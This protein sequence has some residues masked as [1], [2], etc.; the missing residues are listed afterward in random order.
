[1]YPQDS[2]K[3]FYDY[4]VAPSIVKYFSDYI[5]PFPYRKLANVQSKTIFGGMENASAIF[6]AEK[7]VTGDRSSEALIAHEIAHQWFGNTATETTFAHLW[8]SEGF[9]TYLTDIYMENKYGRDTLRHRMQGERETVLHFAARSDKPV[10]DSLSSPM[11][12]LNANSYQ[13]GGWVLHMLRQEVGDT[14]FRKILQEYYE[15]YKW[16]NAGTRDFEAVAERVSGKELTQFFDQWLYRG[17][18]PRLNI[19]TSIEKDAVSV[20]IGQDGTLFA[21]PIEVGLVM[22]DGTMQTHRVDVSAKETDVKIPAPGVTKVLID[23][24]TKLLFARK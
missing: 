23:P 1:V 16:R 9:A 18:V 17:R 20:H 22:G 5:A 14:V 8:L 4:A 13:K 11:D 10:V 7:T 2:T 6:Y 12:L 3:G 19:K 15:Q 24:A 21:F